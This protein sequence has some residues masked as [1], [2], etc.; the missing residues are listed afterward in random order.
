MRERLEQHEARRVKAT[1][2]YTSLQN[3]VDTK[4]AKLSKLW[5]KLQET[6]TDIQ[7]IH[8]DF[9]ASRDNVQV[10]SG[11]DSGDGQDSP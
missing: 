4:T 6:K 3:E 10:G 1:E 5:N 2:S 7:A 8:D 9:A 11:N